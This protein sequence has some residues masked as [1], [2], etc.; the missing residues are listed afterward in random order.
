MDS[1]GSAKMGG[2]YYKPLMTTY[3]AIIW[4]FFGANPLAFRIPLLI[5]HILS[6]YIVFLFSMS[7]L[8]RIPSLFVA[9][10]FLLHPINTEVVLYIADA[11]DILY[12]FFGI[13][14]LYMIES[15]E[16][17]KTLFTM[18]LITFSCGLL[19]KETGALFLIIGGAYAFFLRPKKLFPV[20][21]SAAII[22]FSYLLLRFQIGLTETKN[23]AL[24]FHSASFLDRLRMLP[25]ILG[26]YIEIFFFPARLS[27]ATDF[28]LPGITLELFWIP[29]IITFIFL[30]I[31]YKISR[32]LF[33]IGHKNIT[34][35]F[36]STIFFWFVLHGQMLI[37]LDGV[38][39]DRWFYIG[40]WALTSLLVLLLS[41]TFSIK[42]LS[43]SLTLIT[44]LFG[45][46]CF[47]H[48]SDWQDPKVL[49]Q[50]ELSL[51][52]WDAIMAN[53]VG[54]ML[55]RE[56]QIP[57]S[58]SYFT[59]STQLN[60]NWNVA[61]NN[62]GAVKE[63]QQKFSEALELYLKSL[64]ISP[65]PL[66]YENYVNLLIKLGEKEKA[67]QFLKLQALPLYPFNKTLIAYY[68]YLFEQVRP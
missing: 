21:S 16:N 4:H 37:P 68:N 40:V 34:L 18:L 65:Y 60:P 10:I 48:S 5:L 67:Y 43:A 57:E 20:F 58:E 33:S 39:A 29:L 26:H 49:Y 3:Y 55:F 8:S 23:P 30:L 38:Y 7:F 27:L 62:L 47:T 64:Q 46:R 51:H 2:I 50:R 11:Q 1:G 63:N 9:L 66:A 54:V 45:I 15:L 44:L 36:L 52:P 53:N 6:T 42:K 25:L 14:S 41:H 19:S 13:I 32:Y 12:F 61:W 24:L 22:G 17:K 31:L 35:F 59:K 28:V 56:Q